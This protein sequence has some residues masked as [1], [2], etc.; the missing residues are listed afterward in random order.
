[1]KGI[2]FAG[3][4][5]TW[6]QGLHFYS[7]LPNEGW[8]DDG[9]N[10]GKNVTTSHIKFIESQRFAR[11]VA[12]HFNTFEVCRPYNGGNNDEIFEFLDDIYD[13][14]YLDR[15]YKLIIFIFAYFFPNEVLFFKINTG[16]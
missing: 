11:K 8:N 1:M 4:S 10:E 3:D 16:F 14:D 7:D 13:R 15:G 6:G 5:Y 2:I 12:N 9:Y